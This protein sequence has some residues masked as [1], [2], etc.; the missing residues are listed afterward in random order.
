MSLSLI[1]QNIFNERLT[2]V[3]SGDYLPGVYRLL[4]DKKYSLKSCLMFA[5]YGGLRKAYF[6]QCSLLIFFNGIQLAWDC[7]WGIA[8]AITRHMELPS[9]TS[10]WG[11]PHSACIT[12]VGFLAKI[13]PLSQNSPL[14]FRH[15]DRRVFLRHLAKIPP[16]CFSTFGNKGGGFWLEI[17]LIIYEGVDGVWCRF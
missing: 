15:F 17:Q 5:G 9:T 12:S 10:L 1:H 11:S 6:F 13:P 3:N 8:L 4:I 7:F 16:P 2:R 14:V